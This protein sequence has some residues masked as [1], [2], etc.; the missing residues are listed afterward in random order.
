[1]VTT[2]EAGEKERVTGKQRADL[3]SRVK[4]LRD[5]RGF[6]QMRLA[7]EAGLSLS[8][9]S[10][11]EQAR[12]PDPRGSTLVRIAEALGVKVDDLLS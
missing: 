12:I 10:Q 7:I 5:S 8:V 6:T 1:M 4:K 11:I 3:G 2:F 9:V